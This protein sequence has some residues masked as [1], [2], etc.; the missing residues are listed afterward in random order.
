[1]SSPPA[2][3]RKILVRVAVTV[4]LLGGGI[5]AISTLH[6]MDWRAFGGALAGV[7]LLP[8]AIALAVSTLQVFAQLLR[9]YVLVPPSVMPP[10][11]ELLDATA[12]GQLLN[13]ATPLRAGDAYKL[14]RL[15]PG[16]AP[17]EAKT[18]RFGTLLA[19]L[20]VE[21][22]A[23]VVGLFVMAA[24]ASLSELEAWWLSVLPTA[25]TA[26]K[27]AIAAVAVA[28]LLAVL[29]RRLPRALGSFFGTTWGALRSPRF[30]ASIGVAL[31]TWTLD[32]GTLYWTTRAGGYPL[33]FREVMQSVF[34]LNLGSRCPSPWATSASSRRPWRS[35][36][37]DTESRRRGRWRSRRWSTSPSSRGWGCVWGSFAW[38]A[39]PF[40]DRCRAPGLAPLSGAPGRPRRLK[41]RNDRDG[42][43][44][45]AGRSTE[46]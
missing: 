33:S 21:R 32:A 19:A 46:G 37:R 6:G 25:G 2:S 13:Y 10:L 11:W 30:A 4:I 23:D 36:C 5:G 44:S 45:G 43:R 15:A 3:R 12:I 41:R 26:W 1:M 7:A 38:R 14:L 8:L 39:S 27:I 18:G 34:V 31:L 22:A 42:C 40:G 24:W 16:A 28:L 9:F 29:A 17:G 35:R 20:L